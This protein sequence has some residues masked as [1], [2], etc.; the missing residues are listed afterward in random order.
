MIDQTLYRAL[1]APTRRQILRILR[2]GS[3]SAG[4]IATHFSISKASL[5]HHFNLLKQAELLLTERRGQHIVYSLDTTVMQDAATVLIELLNP[6]G[7][8]K[9]E[10]EP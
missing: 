9:E 6:A 5:S 3:Q 7:V 10:K 8:M 2:Q 1:A 4:E